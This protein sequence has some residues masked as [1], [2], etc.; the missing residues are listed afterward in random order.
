MLDQP[1]TKIW[2]AFWVEFVLTMEVIKEAKS[3]WQL[4]RVSKMWWIALWPI[5]G[6]T[7]DTFFEQK[8]RRLSF[9][10]AN[11]KLTLNY[12][13]YLWPH[14]FTD[15]AALRAELGKHQVCP[16]NQ[17][18]PSYPPDRSLSIPH[19]QKRISPPGLWRQG[20]VVTFWGMDKDSVIWVEWG[21]C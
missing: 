2:L 10:N 6:V 7:I 14:L 15:K 9:W 13:I 8:E 19:R 18:Q 12:F 11:Y 4:L 3:S 20:H 21:P 16:S 1:K 17:L 5:S